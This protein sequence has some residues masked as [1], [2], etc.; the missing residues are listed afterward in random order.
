MGPA[1]ASVGLAVHCTLMAACFHVSS[2]IAA[3]VKQLIRVIHKHACHPL[4]A[5][6]H[7]L[8]CTCI[9]PQQ[10]A[11]TVVVLVAG[12]FILELSQRR[13]LQRASLTVGTRQR[14]HLLHAQLKWCCVGACA[15]WTVMPGQICATNVKP[16]RTCYIIR[17]SKNVCLPSSGHAS[18]LLRRGLQGLEMQMRGVAQVQTLQGALDRRAAQNAGFDH[19]KSSL[20]GSHNI[21]RAI[22]ASW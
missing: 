4:R 3:V 10:P 13:P 1:S 20:I 17:G 21:N 12:A 8:R 5:A 2:Q 16:S 9:A 6:A 11:V 7:L 19:S 14:L 18:A 22:F 15:M